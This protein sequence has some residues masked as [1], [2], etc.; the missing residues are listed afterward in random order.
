MHA[1]ELNA[2]YNSFV[3]AV[4]LMN[5]CHQ[6]LNAPMVIAVVFLQEGQSSENQKM[7]KN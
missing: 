7:I 5:E 4:A 6:H 2:S 3:I 1:W